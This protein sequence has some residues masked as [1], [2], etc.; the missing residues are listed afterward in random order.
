M[1]TSWHCA[2]Q[3]GI[4][5]LRRS[6]RATRKKRLRGSHPT[7]AIRGWSVWSFQKKKTKNNNNNNN[8]SNSRRIRTS[9]RTNWRRRKRYRAVKRRMRM[10]SHHRRTRRRSGIRLGCREKEEERGVTTRRL[11]S[12]GIDTRVS[13]ML[14]FSFEPFHEELLLYVY[15]LMYVWLV[16][17]VRVFYND[18][19]GYWFW[20]LI[21]TVTCILLL[22]VQN[23]FGGNGVCCKLGFSVWFPRNVI[24]RERNR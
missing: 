1:C 22:L 20:I 14:G 15:V 19:L 11:N 3:W 5:D 2:Q 23:N 16:H 12:T 17:L 13:H 10:K 24:E 4:R 8:K 18:W 9:A 21:V 7:R 6:R